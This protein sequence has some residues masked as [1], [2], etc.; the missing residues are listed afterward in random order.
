MYV[1]VCVCAALDQFDDEHTHTHTRP[2]D[3]FNASTSSG[4]TQPDDVTGLVIL[5]WRCEAPER[6]TLDL[7]EPRV[8]VHGRSA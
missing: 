7:T 3:Y 4:P 8:E 5:L 6:L 1:Y 2:V